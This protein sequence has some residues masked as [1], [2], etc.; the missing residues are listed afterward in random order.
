MP[1][2]AELDSCECMFESGGVSL[3]L[4]QVP[5]ETLRAVESEAS[6][7]LATERFLPVLPVLEPLL[8]AAGVRRGATVAVANS[9]SLALALVAG[10]S[11]A[12]AWV[13]AVGLPD[14]GVVAAAEA[15]VVLDRF[16]LVPEVPRE[17][18]AAVVAACVDGMDA[19]VAAPPPGVRSDH[20]RRL[21]ARARERRTVLV[22]T[23]G[24]L[25][26]WPH[27]ADLRLTVEHSRWDGLDQGHGY[28][29]TRQVEV[30][31]TGRGT[32]AR[33]CHLLL[34]GPDGS[35]VAA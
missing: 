28:L 18:W 2:G 5:A 3:G 21:A 1:T 7:A 15:G 10:G 17:R 8:G 16:A 13:A 11:A 20:A 34:P 35:A 23:G 6:G 14:L 12:G 27:P 4:G 26:A 24:A 31:A 25:P 29:A 9:T 22:L 33:R 19:V 30:T 32:P